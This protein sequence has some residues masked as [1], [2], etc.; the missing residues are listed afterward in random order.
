MNGAITE[1]TFNFFFKLNYDKTFDVD[2]RRPRC[3]PATSPLGELGWALI[4]GGLYAVGF[5]VVMVLLGLIVSPWVDPRVPGGA[6][7][8]VRLRRRR[9]GRDVVHA[10]VAGL[11]PDPARDPAA[12]PVLGDVLPDRDLPAR[13]SRSSSSSRRSTR[14][15]TCIRS[16][17]VGAIRPILL[18]HVAYLRSWD[19][20]AA[21]RLAAARQAAAQVGVRQRAPTRDDAIAPALAALTAEIVEC[22]RCPRLVAWR[23]RVAREKVARFRD[24]TYWGRPVPGFGDPDGA[25]PARSASRRRPTAAT[26]PGA[27][28]PA[29]RR[30]TS[31]SRR[32]I[33]AGLGRSAVVAARPTTG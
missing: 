28:S 31:C 25:D 4:R 26:G 30:A 23:E 18:V 16:L 10:D 1:T 29:T 19:R 8:R 9:D 13:R 2:P 22:R 6:A 12:V 21:R 11:R 20:R 3:R 15:S 5:L 7:R 24:E 14:A 27:S 33:A 32:S 17:T